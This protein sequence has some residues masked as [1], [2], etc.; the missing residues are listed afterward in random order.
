MKKNKTTKYKTTKAL[1]SF[2]TSIIMYV[3]V[4]FI[5]YN[6]KKI[7]LKKIVSNYAVLFI[8]LFVIIGTVEFLASK[9]ADV[10]IKR[11]NFSN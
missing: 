10:W 5:L 6:F 11:R 8:T 7:T 2:I 1:I 3:I 4:S 9:I